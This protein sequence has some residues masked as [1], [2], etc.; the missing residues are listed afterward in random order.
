MGISKCTCVIFVSM[1]KVLNGE[2]DDGIEAKYTKDVLFYVYVDFEYHAIIALEVC[3][4][5]T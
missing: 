2:L 3:S 1:I 4:C 5:V